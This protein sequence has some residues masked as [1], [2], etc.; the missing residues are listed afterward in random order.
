[1]GWKT[2][3]LVLRRGGVSAVLYEFVFTKHLS[4]RISRKK[5]PNKITLLLIPVIIIVSLVLLNQG[6]GT[7]SIYASSISF[8]IIFS[9]IMVKRPDLFVDAVISG[10]LLAIIM[11]VFYFFYLQ[12]VDLSRIW[13]LYSG[14]GGYMLLGRIPLTEMVWAIT[15]GMVGG[16]LYEFA[17][18]YKLK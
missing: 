14:K 2:C 12:I 7:N 8:L 9:L 13:F 5:V 16:P 15:W 3:F 10:I 11:G 1:M 17:R 6:L 4:K 18:G